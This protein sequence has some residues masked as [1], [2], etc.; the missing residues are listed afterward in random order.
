MSCKGVGPWA[1]ITWESWQKNMIILYSFRKLELIH[2]INPLLCSSISAYIASE[3]E[4]TRA[5][6][7]QNKNCFQHDMQEAIRNVVLCL[8]STEK[9]LLEHIPCF[10]K[11]KNK[12][13]VA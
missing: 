13:K 12:H 6:A 4:T 5:L 2:L 3:S 8:Q 9:Q 7:T 10:N 1:L 11:V